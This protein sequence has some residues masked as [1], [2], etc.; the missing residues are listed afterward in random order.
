VTYC[1]PQISADIIFQKVGRRARN[2][3]WFVVELTFR[4]NNERVEALGFHALPEGD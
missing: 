4:G 3:A 2:Q 1:P